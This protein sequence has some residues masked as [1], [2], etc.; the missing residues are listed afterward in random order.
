MKTIKYL[1]YIVLGTL[2]LSLT[3]CEPKA[4][5][6]E[7][8]FLSPTLTDA[9]LAPDGQIYTLD[10][11]QKEFMTP[12]GSFHSDSTL[13]RKR[14]NDKNFPDIYLFTIDTIR[15]DGPG[16]YIRGRVTTDDYAGNFYKSMVIQQV[17][18]GE[19]QNLRI[20]V[21]MGSNGGLYQIGQEIIIRCN[22][23]AIARYANQ[24]QLCVAT[25]ND[26]IYASHADEKIGWESG[27]IPA[28]VFR[29]AVRLIGTPRQD[30]LKYKEVTLAQFYAEFQQSPAVTRESLDQVALADG[31][32]IR[33]TDVYFDGKYNKYGDLLDMVA[34]NPDPGDGNSH[35]EI[36]VF[37]PT[38]GNLN[39]PQSRVLTDG[40]NVIMCSS[41]EY[42]KYAHFYIPGAD[43]TGI[44]DCPNWKGQV[45]GILGWYCDNASGFPGS[46]TD[47][48]G[49]NAKEYKYN[50]S[51]TPRG[52]EGFGISDIKVEKDGQA[53]KP[54]EYNPN[55]S[56]E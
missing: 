14:A 50:W 53:W 23:L 48:K 11:F 19:Q 9:E 44:A 54:V 45:S 46:S 31:M 56:A 34:G 1:S 6:Q 28:A 40:T 16:I 8:I 2:V 20:S 52:I 4:L 43:A 15:K 21:D 25:Y 27:R 42:C 47:G 24:P 3:S 37:A 10:N 29:N 22:G 30:L 35:S 33:F 26:K 17:V 36:N 18:N 7:D 38:T 55:P 5:E 51:V 41:S 39:F 13:Y 32:L 49:E 12:E